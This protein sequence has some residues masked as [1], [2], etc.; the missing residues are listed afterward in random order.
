MNAHESTPTLREDLAGF[1]GDIE[2]LETVVATW[3]ETQ[4]GVVSAYKIAI[5]ALNAEAFRRL[6]RALKADP[7]ALA[8]MKSAASDELVYA[9][10]RRYNL[11]RAALNERV[12]QALESVRPMLKSHGGD[13]ELV[14]VRPPAVEVRFKGAC[15]GCPASALT[16]HA[17]V[18]KALQD[19]CPE[20]TDVIQVKGLAAASEGGVR[21]ISPFALNAEGQWIPAG[22]W[23]DFP[24]GLVRAMELGGRKI[25]LSRSGESISCFENACAHLGLPIHD[26][27]VQGGIITC[28]YHGFRYDLASGECLTAPEVQLQ[29]HAVR[30]I[31]TRVEVRIT[32]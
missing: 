21:F 22:A 1:V 9:V 18:K 8:A 20:I 28:P 13:V 32:A 11:L 3:D 31:G 29:P 26:G 6:I 25:I 23:A 14:S 16:F 24:E 15:D 27:E 7:A 5:E 17:G 12:E 10:L 2:R 19:V 4:R 30:I